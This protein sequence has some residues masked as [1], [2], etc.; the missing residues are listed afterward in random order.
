MPFC[1][2][3]AEAHAC[4]CVSV[5][6]CVGKISNQTWK[7]INSRGKPGSS[8]LLGYCIICEGT[9]ALIV[10]LQEY[11]ALS[12][13]IEDISASP[14]SLA[15]YAE[16]QCT[17][18]ATVYV[19]GPSSNTPTSVLQGAWEDYGSDP[20]QSIRSSGM[21]GA[22]AEQRKLEEDERAKSKANKALMLSE[23]AA[24]Q[25]VQ[26]AE[27]AKSQG[28]I[29]LRLEMEKFEAEQIAEAAMR[30]KLSAIASRKRYK[31]KMKALRNQAKDAPVS[32]RF[33]AFCDDES[34][35]ESD[36]EAVEETA[37]LEA[38]RDTFGDD[39]D[40]ALE[41][42]SEASEVSDDESDST[43]E[44]ADDTFDEIPWEAEAASHLQL[45]APPSRL[46]QSSG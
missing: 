31:D 9:D 21:I 39:S 41:V 36:D 4:C 46:L 23:A 40:N 3:C 16:H 24:Q 43:E 14:W 30:K 6:F 11:A 27:D 34:D 26:K 1:A 2:L 32:S 29:A 18:E 25:Q 5:V 17:F 8:D 35:G 45:P 13:T 37:D 28:I 15:N 12:L 38:I 19:S 33:G 20:L 10:A 44:E 42:K 7:I 22:A